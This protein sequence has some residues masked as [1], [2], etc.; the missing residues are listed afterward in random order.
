M[1]TLPKRRTD[2]GLFWAPKKSVKHPGHF[3]TFLEVI[4]EKG[5]VKGDHYLP[6]DV[7][8]C[9]RSNCLYTFT[10]EADKKRHTRGKTLFFVQ[11]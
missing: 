10:S 4:E 3:E 11:A 5:E 9:P 1:D 8:T 7:E 6:E 2:G